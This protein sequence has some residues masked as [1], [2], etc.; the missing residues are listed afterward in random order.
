MLPPKK[1]GRVLPR[2]GDM[3]GG[4]RA[5]AKRPRQCETIGKGADAKRAEG[6]A[7]GTSG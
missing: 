5:R 2:E 4:T 1:L 7:S 3:E 6:G